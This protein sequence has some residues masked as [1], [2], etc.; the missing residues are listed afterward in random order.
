MSA[1]SS[2]A[3]TLA[4]CWIIWSMSAWASDALE[5]RNCCAGA[6]EWQEPQ[7]ASMIAVA[8][9]D[10]LDDELPPDDEPPLED[11]EP[12]DDPEPPPLSIAAT[13]CWN[14][15]RSTCLS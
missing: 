1:C 12:E 14:P 11:E 3:L 6:A 10:E 13:D 7:R 5:A 4:P 15:S 9:E 8:L 2:A